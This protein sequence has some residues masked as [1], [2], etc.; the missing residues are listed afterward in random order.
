MGLLARVFELAGI[1][2]KPIH[3][4]AEGEHY[5]DQTSRSFSL[6]F[7]RDANMQKSLS[8]LKSGNN[9][10]QLSGTVLPRYNPGV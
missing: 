10:Y 2:G 6:I 7:Y 5:Q 8:I 3:G 1:R 4:S 9:G